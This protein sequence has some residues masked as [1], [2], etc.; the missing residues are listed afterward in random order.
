[1]AYT[2]IN[3]E[4]EPSVNTP[5]NE[6]NLNHMEDGIVQNETDI[7]GKMNANNPTGTGSLQVGTGNM[8]TDGNPSYALGFNAYAEGDNSFAFGSS[9]R[10]KKQGAYAIGIH[11]EARELYSMALG[12]EVIA[13]SIHQTVRGKY[14]E[15]DADGVYL[16]IVGG[17]NPLE[18]KN[19]ETLTPNGDKWVAGDYTNGNGET[20]HGAYQSAENVLPIDTESGNPA[21]ITDAFGG[22]C[23]SLKLTLEPI[24]SGSGTPSP[25]NVRPFV[26]FTQATINRQG[27]NLCEEILA[28]YP[29]AN[30]NKIIGGAYTSAV[31]FGVAGMTVVASANQQNRFVLAYVGNNKPEVGDTFSRIYQRQN[32]YTLESTGYYV[33]Y[34]CNS[35]TDQ[36]QVEIGTTATTYE[37]YNGA[38]YTVDLDGTRYGGTVD[39]KTGV[40]TVTHLMAIYDGSDDESWTMYGTGSA[41]AYA[42]I[43]RL[44]SVAEFTPNVLGVL[45]ASY[46]ENVSAQATWGNYD[47]FISQSN[48]M[49]GIDFVMGL[50]NI[51]T[52]VNALKTYLAEHSLTICY[53]LATPITVQLTPE[54]VTLL[55][56]NNVLTANGTSI[57]V[58]YSADVQA[59][60]DKKISEGSNNNRSVDN[61]SLTKGGSSDEEVKEE[62]K[63]EEIEIKEEE[64][65]KEETR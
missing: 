53:K 42:V 13:A 18:R 26:G 24:Q 32:Y 38:T 64:P 49:T 15:I 56:L 36:V 48:A 6:D 45:T 61:S 20:L 30:Q 37:A 14:N 12:E 16:D 51:S 9:T 21:V 29:D 11:A 17:G 33:W 8:K 47:Y 19:V 25:V 43:G 28:G 35:A 3:W 62:V 4:N 34:V 58:S 23:K 5:I 57:S 65:K 31:F 27:K 39:F 40:L 41:S 60:I 7:A 22:A 63:E 55:R 52:S 2:R 59:Y 50:K 10:A 44:P 1:M 54:E 46:L